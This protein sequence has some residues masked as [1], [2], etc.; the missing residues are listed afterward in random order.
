MKR[1][2]AVN[3]GALLLA[4]LLVAIG[5]VRSAKPTT[6]RATT[7]ALESTPGVERVML[8]DG[9]PAV[10]DAQG[11]AVPLVRYERIVSLGLESD[12]LLAEL[13]ERN[14]LAR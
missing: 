9:R 4:L 5:T 1:L 7:P 13:C 2:D 3:L 8:A 10:R 14:R 12:A 11:E 6:T